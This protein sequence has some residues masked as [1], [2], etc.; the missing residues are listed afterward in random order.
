[1]FGDENHGAHVILHRV[2]G[3][4]KKRGPTTVFNRFSWDDDERVGWMGD[5]SKSRLPGLSIVHRWRDMSRIG[6]EDKADEEDTHSLG[7][8]KQHFSTGQTVIR[9]P[10]H[11]EVL[12]QRV[13]GGQWGPVPCAPGHERGWARP[14]GLNWP[15]DRN[16]FEVASWSVFAV[17]SDTT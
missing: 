8:S 13:K 6:G 9:I 14:P 16:W 5:V 2:L 15:I 10:V 7:D 4:R 12:H 3:S 1:M 17:R 11:R